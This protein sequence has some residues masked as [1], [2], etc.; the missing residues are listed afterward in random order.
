MTRKHA[1]TLLLGLIMALGP[2]ATVHGA[3]VAKIGV[4]DFQQIL[5][6]SLAGKNA[7]R[8][9]RQKQDERSRDLEKLRQDIVKLQKYIEGIDL[10]GDKA[11]REQKKMELSIKLDA[12]N[13]ADQRYASQLK[14]INEKQMADIKKR[15]FEVAETLGK[16]GGYL[17][18]LEKNQ[19]VY[20]PGTIDITGK[21]IE[22]YNAD[23]QRNL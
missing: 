22:V 11:D 6:E 17:L 4:V 10:L 8:L 19:I 9:M 1:M 20:A 21:V 12:F 18:I 2:V 16:K 7:A 23:F 13:D 15:V 14:E 5:K 3:D